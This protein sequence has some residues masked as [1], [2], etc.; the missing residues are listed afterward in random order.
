MKEVLGWYYFVYTF[1]AQKFTSFKV[2][3]SDKI[4]C[5]YILINF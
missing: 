3:S 4:L 5:I 2:S 1:P